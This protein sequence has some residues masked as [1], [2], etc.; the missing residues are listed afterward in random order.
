VLLRHNRFDNGTVD[1]EAVIRVYRQRMADAWHEGR[2][3]LYGAENMDYVASDDADQDELMDGIL[4]VLPWEGR[5]PLRK[6]DVQVVVNYRT[7]RSKHLL[8]IW[9]QLGRPGESFSDF[10]M[11]GGKCLF[12]ADSLR[13]ALRFL[14]R[15]LATTIVDMWGLTE[16]SIDVRKAYACDV[17]RVECD[18]YEIVSLRDRNST[19]WGNGNVR[20]GRG[21]MDLSRAQLDAIEGLMRRYD[22]GLKDGVERLNPK[23]LFK[24]SLFA[25]CSGDEGERRL[26]WLADEIQGVVGK[27]RKLQAQRLCGLHVR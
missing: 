25:G 19:F 9:H 22:C 13:V 18:N 7:P 5:P 17:L 4:A 24:N 21:E 3:I 2:D 26:D 14:E 11:D 12:R 6:Q 27:A 15:G 20:T 10:L 16:R 23:V 8:S 1:R